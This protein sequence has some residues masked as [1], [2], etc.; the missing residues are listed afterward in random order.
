M[1]LSGKCALGRLGKSDID[2]ERSCSFGLICRGG[3]RLC[4]AKAEKLVCICGGGW[5]RGGG[6]SKSGSRWGFESK[7]MGAEV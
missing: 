5:G 4:Q 2:P 1:E 6:G 7:E 3:H